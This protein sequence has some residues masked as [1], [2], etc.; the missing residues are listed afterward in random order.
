MT[1]TCESPKVVVDTTN[2]FFNCGFRSVDWGL[3]EDRRIQ[4]YNSCLD[5]AS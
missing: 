2:W 3:K 1:G 5:P 4:A